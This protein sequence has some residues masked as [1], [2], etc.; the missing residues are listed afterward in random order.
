MYRYSSHIASW[1][2]SDFVTI[3]ALIF[4]T[5]CLIRYSKQM[6]IACFLLK[7]AQRIGTI[8]INRALSWSVEFPSQC[9]IF[10]SVHLD[11]YENSDFSA[12]KAVWR[13][14]ERDDAEREDDPEWHSVRWEKTTGRHY[15]SEEGNGTEER[16]GCAA[17]S[18]FAENESATRYF[19]LL[20]SKQRYSAFLHEY[21]YFSASCPFWKSH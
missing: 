11:Q 21:A 4:I 13:D 1:I 16:W 7:P 5:L 18:V 3:S 14:E 8:L 12:A 15:Q 19:P 9:T 17:S 10:L 2:L 20:Q 6:P